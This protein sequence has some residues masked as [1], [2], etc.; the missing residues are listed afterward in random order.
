MSYCTPGLQTLSGCS[1]MVGSLQWLGFQNSH[2]GIQ[3]SSSHLCFHG[4]ASSGQY[5]GHSSQEPMCRHW[6]HTD[7]DDMAR[8]EWRDFHKSHPHTFRI[9][10]QHGSVGIPDKCSHFPRPG[11][12]LFD[13]RRASR[14]NW[15]P[16]GSCTACSHRENPGEHCRRSLV[17]TH[18]SWD[19]SC[20]ADI[21]H[22]CQCMDHTSRRG[23]CSRIFHS[24]R[25]ARCC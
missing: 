20:C 17:S 3:D 9:C 13:T 7:T 21:R 19:P 25:R 4:N 15:P 1:H 6:G 5:G 12:R 23:C 14:P 8:Q 24:V 11:S 18:C 22:I 16:E 10:C 2:P